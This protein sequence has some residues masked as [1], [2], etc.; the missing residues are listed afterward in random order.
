MMTKY[1][2]KGFQNAF[3]NARKGMRLALKSERNIRI[4]VLSGVLVFAFGI[5]LNLSIAKLCILL[6]TIAMVISAE[7]INTAIEF[8]LD[9]IF[10]NKYSTLVGMAKDVSAGAVMLV[11]VVA[12]CVGLLIFV[13]VI[14][15]Y[16]N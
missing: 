6:L 2:A 11:S 15:S 9:S 8:S 7:M 4:H 10:H 14:F 1:K 16:F 13:P 5:F 12:V 3:K